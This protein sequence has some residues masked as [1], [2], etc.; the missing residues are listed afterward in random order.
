MRSEYRGWGIV[1]DAGTNDAAATGLPTVRLSVILGDAGAQ[2]L[3]K[4][5]GFAAVSRN[6][7]PLLGGPPGFSA[8]TGMVLIL[9]GAATFG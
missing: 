7:F 4:R 8:V 2:R 3:H 9:P 1:L 6:R 5:Y